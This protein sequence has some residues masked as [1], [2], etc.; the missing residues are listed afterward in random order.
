MISSVIETLY[1][2]MKYELTDELEKELESIDMEDIGLQLLSTEDTDLLGKYISVLNFI[3][4]ETS[5]ATPVSDDTYD[6]VVALYQEL[7][8]IH[9]IGVTNQSSS[10]RYWSIDIH[11]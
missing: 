1:R 2:F 4:N 7:G 5:I 11:S 3:E 9:G 10:K 8:G 6:K